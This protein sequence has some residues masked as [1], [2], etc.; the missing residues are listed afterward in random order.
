MVKDQYLHS[1]LTDVILQA[2]YKVYNTL[3][4]GFLE[5]VYENAM[6]IELRK[7]GCQVKQQQPLTVYYEDETV[8]EYFADLVVNN[9]II[10]ELKAAE[11]LAHEHECQL[12]NYLKATDLE[13]GLLLNFGVKPEHKRKVFTNDKKRRIAH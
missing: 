2:Y 9:T 8:G 13:V 4:Y 11:K 7:R 12:I 1:E 3:G 6:R 5:K 10:L